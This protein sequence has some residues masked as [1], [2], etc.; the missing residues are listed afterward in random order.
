MEENLLEHVDALINSLEPFHNVALLLRGMKAQFSTTQW[1]DSNLYR[2]F[3]QAFEPVFA[4]LKKNRSSNVVNGSKQYVKAFAQG[5]KSAWEARA[6]ARRH[7]IE[8]KALPGLKA[9][10]DLMTERTED[11]GGVNER[12]RQRA[13]EKKKEKNRMKNLGLKKAK[14]KA[15]GMTEGADAEGEEKEAVVEE[16]V[17]D[18]EAEEQEAL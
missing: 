1:D 9:I 5:V 14:A 7:D 3:I 10:V 12:V 8:E 16:E 6:H 13:A 15:K 2:N 11:R 17:D 4:K 18:A